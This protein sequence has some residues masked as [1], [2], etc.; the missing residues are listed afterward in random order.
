M[1]RSGVK[2]WAL[3]ESHPQCCGD[4]P[5]RPARRDVLSTPSPATRTASSSR[6]GC[7]TCQPSLRKSSS[8]RRAR[9]AT[10]SS[11][12]PPRCARRI[13]RLSLSTMQATTTSS[14]SSRN[15][16]G[17]RMRSSTACVTGTLIPRL[18]ILPVRPSACG[19]CGVAVARLTRRRQPLRGLG[20]ELIGLGPDPSRRYRTRCCAARTRPQ[21][22]RPMSGR[23][24][25]T[26]PSE[27][28]TMPITMAR[29]PG[30]TGERVTT[31]NDLP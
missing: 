1:T 10:R 26:M 2:R 24:K 3:T 5:V 21:A 18:R 6:S 14:L 23:M 13:S 28:E 4:R 17:R 27:T 8:P 7:I 11:G 20:A 12:R 9:S 15:T 25:T 29:T 19:G 31:S 22:I 16:S 30:T